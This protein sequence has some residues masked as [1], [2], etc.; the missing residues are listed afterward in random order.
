MKRSPTR[1]F[2]SRCKRK[3]L[4]GAPP[5]TG[6]A[7]IGPELLRSILAIDPALE[8]IEIDGKVHCY[9][10][11]TYGGVSS[12]DYL[13]WQFEL[14]RRPG[15]WLIDCLN[16]SD[17]WKRFGDG[18]TAAKKLLVK[19]EDPGVVR[20][21]EALLRVSEISEA[22]APEITKRFDRGYKVFGPR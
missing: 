18:E 20:E 21:R 3:N 15:L 6:R 13:V 1:R 5:F 2:I 14:P 10:V 12:D 16:Q 22:V 7:S 8:L 17:T 9:R 19:Y 4:V 11:K